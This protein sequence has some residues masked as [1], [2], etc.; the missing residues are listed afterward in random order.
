MEVYCGLMAVLGASV[1][2]TVTG[3]VALEDTNVSESLNEQTW[4][5]RNIADFAYGIPLD[6][7]TELLDGT[8]ASFPA[9]K[10][11]IRSDI[12]EAE[13][14]IS[15][16]ASREIPAVTIVFQQGEGTVESGDFSASI[17]P[18]VVV[19][20]NSDEFVITVTN[21]GEGRVEIKDIIPGVAINFTNQDIISVN[22]DLRSNLD[23]IDPTFEVSSIEI[24][25]YYP[26]DISE[27]VANLGDDMPIWYYAGYDGDY[28]QTRNFSL[29]EKV[30]E[31]NHIIKIVGNDKSDLLEDSNV[32]I[33]R[34]QTNQRNARRNIYRWM[35][36]IIEDAGIQLQ[37]VEPE[38]GLGTMGESPSQTLV[39]LSGSA[40]E[41]VAN[42]AN[43]CRCPGYNF[44][45]RYVDAGIPSLTWSK[46][47]PKWT[48]YEHDV[49]SLE[50]WADR[51]VAKIKTT[52]D[53]GLISVVHKDEESEVIESD[54]DVKNNRRVTKN[55]SEWYWKYQVAHKKNDSFVWALLD[56]VQWISDYTGKVT[57]SGW[58]LDVEVIKKT[59]DPSYYGMA[60]KYGYT[61]KFDPITVGKLAYSLVDMYPNWYYTFAR[62]NRGGK[63]TWK[64]DPRMQPHDYFR[65][66]RLDGTLQFCTI[67]SIY[68]KH[69]KGGTIAEIT[70][71]RGWV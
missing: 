47:I 37:E 15:G 30:T 24:Q 4:R 20:V 8:L 44:Y 56:T 45:P 19:P 22:L 52:S 67:E 35:K 42:L 55:F 6:G 34:I 69:E 41:H 28:S 58:P 46:P 32:A 54:I 36:G 48:V 71:R 43:L 17:R 39:F 1:E 21:T 53:Y 26:D 50:E 59:L 61:A 62:D 60:K 11:G 63:F 29:S 12:G 10:L 2:Y 68:L 27:A 70:Y 23:I 66:I 16:T 25:A 9:G 33:Q 57:L 3:D 51:N 64:G 7:S 5:M 14:V 49:G 40:R 13:V 38:P 18:T 65:F 31:E